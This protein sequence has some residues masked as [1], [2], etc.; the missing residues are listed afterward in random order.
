MMLPNSISHSP[1]ANGTQTMPRILIL[2]LLVA[3]L[4]ACHPAYPT[5]ADELKSSP[6]GPLTVRFFGVSTILLD[7]GNTA[8]MTDRFFSRPAA[9]KLLFG[10]IAPDKDRIADGL[11]RGD[12]AKL[13]A[14]F[15]VHSHF[16]H[17]MDAPR[18]A[19]Q[20]HALLIGSR[21]TA[22]IALGE[23]FPERCFRLIDGNRQRFAIGGFDVTVFRSLHSIGVP[24]GEA[25]EGTIDAPLHPPVAYTDYKEGDSYSFLIDNGGFRII[26]HASSYYIPGMY[27]GIE[28][29]VVFLGIAT[30]G[31]KSKEFVSKYWREVVTNT[32]AK[33]VVP[34]HWDDFS[35]AL[36]DRPLRPSPYP[37]ED[38]PWAMEM[39]RAL[40][41]KDDVAIR[42]MPLYVPVDIEAA[43]GLPPRARPAPRPEPMPSS[44]P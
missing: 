36:D 6:G 44:C 22:N 25:S 4:G 7:D 28:A 42:F 3:G 16:D 38:F 15:T 26:I 1:N 8:I 9:G 41:G 11:A 33:L 5:G 43:P 31:K 29:D 35:V 27:D 34:I 21:S 24:G 10:R 17:A 20:K 23:G 13:S 18:V 32:K 19:R 2:F 39:L 37:V 12:V 30:L 14:V 40:A